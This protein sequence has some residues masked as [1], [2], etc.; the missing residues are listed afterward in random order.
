M[1]SVCVV[2][3]TYVV[4]VRATCVL[5]SCVLCLVVSMVSR[6]TAVCSI[7]NAIGRCTWACFSVRVGVIAVCSSPGV[8][9]GVL[10]SILRLVVCGWV[11]GSGCS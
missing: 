4:G 7:G 1:L 3:C 5:C 11:L 2:R 10:L 9:V 6:V 8:R